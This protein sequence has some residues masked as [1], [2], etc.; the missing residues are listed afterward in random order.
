MPARK[1]TP[2]QKSALAMLARRAWTAGGHAARSA[3]VESVADPFGLPGPES[4]RF[5]AWRRAEAARCCGRTISEAVDGDYRILA[6]WFTA[7]AA[8][9]PPAGDSP[10]PPLHCAGEARSWSADRR[11]QGRKIQALL[12]DSGLGWAYADGIAR[13]MHGRER[14]E[15]CSPDELRGIIAALTY[16]SRRPTHCH[17]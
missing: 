16:R 15:W 6:N 13:R 5:D 14:V 12:C 9:A 17:A 10:T 7:L 4:R 2:R 8:G 3:T 1:L 11:L